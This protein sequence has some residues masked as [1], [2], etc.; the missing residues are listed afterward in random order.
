MITLRSGLNTLLRNWAS[1]G[2]CGRTWKAVA[3][4]LVLVPVTPVLRAREML[5]LAPILLLLM[6]QGLPGTVELRIFNG[7]SEADEFFLLEML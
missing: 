6:Q 2:S 1:C 4:A 3:V 7:C 5:L